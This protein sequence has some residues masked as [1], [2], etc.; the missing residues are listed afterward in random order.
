MA[1]TLTCG[2]ISKNSIYLLLATIFLLLYKCFYGYTYD[3]EQEYKIQFL[4]N[5]I[6]SEHFLIHQIY[7]YLFCIFLSFILLVK[8]KQENKKKKPEIKK[9]P[10][11]INF[12]QIKTTGSLINDINLYYRE[13]FEKNKY[14]NIKRSIILTCF[15]Y[16]FLE[17]VELIYSRLFPFMEFWMVELCFLVYLNHK[18]FKIEI[19]KHQKLVI[20]IIGFSII[21]NILPLVLTFYDDKKQDQALYVR[22]WW[23]II[24]AII[25]YF[26]DAFCMSYSFIKIKQ[27]INLKFISVYMILLVYGLI[28]LIFCIIYCLVTTFIPSGSL[29]SSNIIFKIKDDNNETYIDNFKVYY[30]NFNKGNKTEIRNEILVSSLGSFAFALYKLY[31]FKII[32]IFTPMHKTFLYPVYYVSQ[33]I[34]L[35]CAKGYKIFNDISKNK[36]LIS[37]LIIDFTSE[38]VSVIGYL[39]YLE[40]IEL[41]FCDFNYNIRRNIIK[42]ERD[43]YLPPIFEDFGEEEDEEKGGEEK[44]NSKDKEKENKENIKDHDENE[45]EQY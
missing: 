9:E 29:P 25:I 17:Q 18:L 37:K 15:V 42:R 33:K 27:L 20:Y 11:N 30:S 21:M 4:D 31:I 28:G 22:H 38:I 23:T 6:F 10:M 35:I 13:D 26:L 14:K 12:M 32:D 3:G 16:I 43:D 5:G 45:N 40:I 36:F 7:I 34:I 44:D 1:K 24:I 19:Y 8:E 39:I 41:N 2:N